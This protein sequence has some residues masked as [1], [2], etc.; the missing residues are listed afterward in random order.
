M[1][2]D[3]TKDEIL[4]RLVQ[5]HDRLINLIDQFTPTEIKTP[6]LLGNWSIRD[7][8]AHLIAHEQR[9]LLEL[10]YA[11]QGQHL[12]VVHAANDSFND[13]ATFACSLFDGATMRAVWEQSYRRVVETVAALPAEIFLPTS[14]AVKIL[15]DSIDGALGNNTYGHYAEHRDDVERWLHSLHNMSP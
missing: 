4:R 13:G 1:S 7:L 9:A 14:S 8:F 2:F 12:H 15:D 10:H 3:V 6:G 5:E 11:Q